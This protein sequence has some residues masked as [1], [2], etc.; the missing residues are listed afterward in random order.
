VKEALAAL[1][2][3][4][5]VG[6]ATATA[7]LAAYDPTTT[8]FMADEALTTVRGPPRC[9][10]ACL[11]LCRAFDPQV[12]GTRNYTVSEALGLANALQSR[13]TE[14]NKAAAAVRAGGAATAADDGDTWTA[15]RVQMTLWAAAVKPSSAAGKTAK[16]IT[17]AEEESVQTKKA[18][19]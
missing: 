15:Q 7:V 19:R 8:P 6:P 3:L 18:R 4:K 13:A 17:H 9:L 11:L 5:G 1:C 16:P 12:L 14:L 2:E 10:L